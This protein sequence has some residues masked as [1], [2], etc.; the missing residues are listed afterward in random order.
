M[1]CTPFAAM[2]FA[3]WLPAARAAEGPVDPSLLV[4]V[5]EQVAYADLNWDPCEEANAAAG[6]DADTICISMDSYYR[7]RY[8]V[9][10]VVHGIAPGEEVEFDLG[11]HYGDLDWVSARHALL[12]VHLHTDE[13]NWMH[14]YQGYAVFP[15]AGGGWATCGRLDWSDGPASRE[16]EFAP[17]LVVDDMSRLTPAGVGYRWD[18]EVYAVVDGQVRCRVGVPLEEVVA[19]VDRE[20]LED[21]ALPPMSPVARGAPEPVAVPPGDVR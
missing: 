7:A 11:S 10:D 16:I 18:P 5:G 21:V 3:L 4:F 2:L 12:F 19:Y 14:K 20:I 6:E 17:P 1:R 15:T 8:R 9:L 13:P